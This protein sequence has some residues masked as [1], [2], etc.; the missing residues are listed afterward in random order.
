MALL[1]VAG[2]AGAPLRAQVRVTGGVTAYGESYHRT[3]VGLGARPDETGRVTANLTIDFLNGLF[4]VPL[5]ALLATDGVQ[6]R[7]QIN[8]VGISPTYRSLTVHLGSFV[9]QY[10][11]YTFADAMLTGAGFDVSRPTFRVGAVAGRTR[12]AVPAGALPFFS[13]QDAPEF[14]RVSY[15]AHLGV[16]PRERS[17]VE[18]Y[19]LAAA[20]DEGSLDTAVTNNFAVSAQENVVTGLMGRLV[21][22]PRLALDLEAAATRLDPNAAVPAPDV[23]GKA[24]S[25][26]IVYTAASWSLGGTVEYLDG[27]FRTFGNSGLVGDRVDAGLT[28]SARLAAG[29]AQ[30][31]WMGGWRRD[32]LSD[33]LAATTT[34]AIFNVSAVVQPSPAFGVTLVAANN[35]NDSKA[36]NDTSTVQH[37]ASQYG[38]TPHW[39]W[40]TGAAQHTLVVSANYQRSDNLKSGSAGLVDTK[41]STFLGTWTVTFPSGLAV[42]LTGTRTQVDLDTSKTSVSTVQPGVAY[43]FARKVQVSLQAQLTNIDTP[44]GGSETEVRPVGQARYAFAQGQSVVLRVNARHHDSDVTGKFDERVVSLQYTA[45][46]R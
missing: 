21:L 26:K 18:L 13:L 2:A 23:S 34:Q 6:F 24:A 7:Q 20:D 12:R 43:T 45:S 11:R 32:N 31:T 42:S 1:L 25:G 27:G 8:Q 4:T 15:G 16:G 29:K 3:G 39:Q 33:A 38:V 46:W 14:Q 41:T 22:G 5:T 44:A 19:V 17:F 40:R 30:V 36:K 9:P 37:V 35:V 10:S 28:G